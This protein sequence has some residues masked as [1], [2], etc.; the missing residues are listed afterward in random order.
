MVYTCDDGANIIPFS[1]DSAY[2]TAMVPFYCSKETVTLL[3]PAEF[4]I[5]QGA[6]ADTTGTYDSTIDV[7]TD[8]ATRW[9]T[10]LRSTVTFGTL[11]P[12]RALGESYLSSDET[13]LRWDF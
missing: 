9:F 11:L 10:L 5:A 6:P 12:N 3:I 7:T 8:P 4:G 13:F 1:G 2:Q